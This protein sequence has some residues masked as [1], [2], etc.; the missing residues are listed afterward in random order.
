M[1][2][3]LV[4]MKWVRSLQAVSQTGLH[5]CLNPYDRERFE[6]VAAVAAEMLARGSTL[7]LDRTLNLQGC[8][9]GY[10]TP[11][12]DVRGVVFQN[13]RILLVSER[14]DD[15]RWTLPG[16]WADVNETPSQAIE[17]EVGEESGFSVRTEKLLAV[18]D[19]DKQGHVPTFPYTVY[20]MFFLCRIVSGQAKLNHEIGAI[21]F[22]EMQNLPELSASRVNERQLRRFY[23]HLHHPQWPTE[24]D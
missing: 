17:R 20:K 18:Y 21:D 2:D 7:G 8:D 12:V 19:R 10:A 1:S 22:F 5:Y 14:A 9:L 24:F 4:W 6:T 3:E 13:D 16:G 23:Q 11:K 15:G